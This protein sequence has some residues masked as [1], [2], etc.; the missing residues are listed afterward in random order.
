MDPQSVTV[1]HLF[2]FRFL[3]IDLYTSVSFVSVVCVSIS[4]RRSVQGF[5]SLLEFHILKPIYIQLVRLPTFS[6]SSTA[7]MHVY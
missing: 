5:H 4:L 3:P 7:S 6:T 1:F 2:S